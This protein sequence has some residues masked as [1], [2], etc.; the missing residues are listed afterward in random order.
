MVA[1]VAMVRLHVLRCHVHLLHLRCPATS[2]WPCNDA[3]CPAM[4]LT[5]TKNCY[6]LLFF[7][8]L[9]FPL[10]PPAR[11]TPPTKSLGL[12]RG[13]CLKGSFFSPLSH[14]CLL[15]RKLLELLGPTLS[16]KCLEITLVMN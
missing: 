12:V 4:P 8:F 13:F 11:Q 6:K 2:C 5:T 1:A 15:W 7:L 14:C 16:V 9:L 10:T 3:Q